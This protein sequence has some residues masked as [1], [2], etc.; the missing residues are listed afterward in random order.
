[1]KA[2][3]KPKAIVRDRTAD[4][5]TNTVESHELAFFDAAV[6]FLVVRREGPRRWEKPFDDFPRALHAA[7]Q[8]RDAGYQMLMY[9]V[10]QFGGASLL[11]A[12]RWREFEQRWLKKRS[13]GC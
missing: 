13:V 11:P 7:Q 12:D 9:A 2:P 8:L 6:S 5:L 10:D 1:M 3:R 4:P